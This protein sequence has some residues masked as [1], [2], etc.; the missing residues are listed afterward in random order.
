MNRAFALMILSAFSTTA[1]AESPS[2]TLP[3]MVTMD[4][5][6]RVFRASGFDVLLA[7][8]QI[9]AAEADLRT[10]RSVPNPTLNGGVGKSFNYDPKAACLNSTTNTVESG[11]SDISWTVGISDSAALADTVFG[12]RHLRIRVAKAALAAAKMTRVDAQ[13]TLEFQVKQQYIQ[14]VLA[15][16]T[17]DFSREVQAAMT[18]VFELNQVRYNAG[19]ISEADVAKVETAKLEADQD[20]NR[21]QQALHDAKV[22][23]AFLL[24]VRGRTPEFHIEQDLPKFVVPAPLADTSLDKLLA[25]ANEHRADLKAASL[26]VERAEVSISAARRQNAPD[27][28]LS[29]QYQQEGSSSSAITPPTLS[30][31]L[32]APFP[33][34]YQFQGEIRRAEADRNIQNLTRAKLEGQ[35]VADVESALVDFTSTRERVERQE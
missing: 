10:A 24:G 25:D 4:E 17:L 31:G 13:R 22:E 28:A 14:A 19:A 2:I 34:F 8:A 29:A 18:Q 23:L 9:Q 26:Q 7:E 6:L 12:K 5:A 15:H 32:S 30:F 20:V 1:R 33:L 35:V 16:D 11:C 27:L 21:A 3:Q